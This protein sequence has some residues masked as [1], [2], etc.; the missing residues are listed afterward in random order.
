MSIRRMALSAA[1]L[2]FS[3]FPVL[4]DGGIEVHDAYARFV[5]G[6]KVGGAFMNIHNHGST[7]DRLLS[8]E[9][10]I[11]AM[12]GVHETTMNADGTMGMHDVEGGI[13]LPAGGAIELKPGGYHIMFMDLKTAPKEG[14]KVPLILNFEAAGA[15]KLEVP[16]ENKH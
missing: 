10:D 2:A 13:A 3:A 11:A 8:V 4:A 5:P 1:I 14:D 12:T 7:D 6:A 16:V 9:S 15:V